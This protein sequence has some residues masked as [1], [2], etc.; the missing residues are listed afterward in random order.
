MKLWRV[1]VELITV[2][3]IEFDEEDAPPTNQWCWGVFGGGSHAYFATEEEA[4]C[5]LREEIKRQIEDL[6][7]K[8]E[9]LGN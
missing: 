9:S 5:V 4:I 6:Q 2:T 8:L 1:D 3:P 7:E